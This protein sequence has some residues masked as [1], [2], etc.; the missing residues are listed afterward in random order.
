MR[1][2]GRRNLAT[3]TFIAVLAVIYLVILVMNRSH[4]SAVVEPY[5]RQDT[6]AHVDSNPLPKSSDGRSRWTKSG[7]R[8]THRKKMKSKTGRPVTDNPDIFD[9]PVPSISR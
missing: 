8:S 9:T 2:P 7:S 5:S 6:V 1:K 4:D 3:L